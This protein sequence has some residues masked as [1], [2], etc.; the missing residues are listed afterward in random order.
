[1]DAVTV[2]AWGG[3]LFWGFDARLVWHRIA[4]LACHQAH[5]E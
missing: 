2:T 1:M 3:P 4:G 5:K